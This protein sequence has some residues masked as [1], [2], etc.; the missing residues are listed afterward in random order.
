MKKIICAVICL[1][2]LTACGVADNTPGAQT[3]AETAVS[4]ETEPAPESEMVSD[5]ETAS[6]SEAVHKDDDGNPPPAEQN[7]NVIR[8]TAVDGNIITGEKMSGGRGFGGGR[9]DGNAPFFDGERPEKGDRPEGEPP[10]M[11]E[12]GSMPDKPE[13]GD[14]NAERPL[15]ET[16][17][18]TITDS[19]VMDM[20]AIS[21]GDMIIAEINEDGT[22]ASVKAADIGREP[23][24]T[25][26]AAT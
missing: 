24:E 23:R 22:A 13:K 2:A 20:E 5:S 26:V 16:V 12:E 1:L 17:T 8:V 19:T 18:F 10:A 7:G 21:E 15:G 25:T 9:P 14:K 4:S 3:S 11:P 6:E